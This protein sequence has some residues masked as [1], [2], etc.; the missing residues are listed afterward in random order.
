MRKAFLWFLVCCACLNAALYEHVEGV[1]DTSVLGQLDVDASFLRDT[2][3]QAMKNNFAMLRQEKFLRILSDAYIYQPMIKQ[4]IADA[5]LPSALVYM[6]MAESSFKPRAYSTARAAGIWQFMSATAKRYGLKVDNY[7]DERRD[8]LK[9]T[10]AAI[11]YLNDLHNRFGKWSLAIM[12][13]NCGEGRVQW[14]INQAGTDDLAVLM[15]VRKGVK[16][17]YLPLETRAYLR[18]ILAM[19]SLAQSETLMLSTS[20]EHL[21]NRGSSYPMVAVEVAP[22]ATLQE[23]ARATSMSVENLRTLN[24]SLRYE[25]VPP[26]G[27]SYSLY[28]PYEKVAQFKQDYVFTQ[29]RN[30]YLVYQVQ[31]GDNLGSIAARHGVPITVI[32]DFNNIK[33]DLIRPKDNLI[34]P[35]ISVADKNEYIVRSGDSLASIARKFNTSVE[36]LRDANHIKQDTIFAGDR[37]VVR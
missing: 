20:T 11:A 9:A 36:R 15:S 31:K 35:V 13:Y 17:Q 18:K 2:E 27:K 33:K 3:F 7:V 21:L 5:G 4:K 8:P 19:A 34:I 25:F 24:P 6:A 14:A 16:K 12:A 22:G 37:I 10:D 30:R 23:I 29:N 1:R 26:Y 28:V 32:R